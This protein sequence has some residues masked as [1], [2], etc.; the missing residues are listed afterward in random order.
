[1]STL[2]VND[3]VSL[4][5]ARAGDTYRMYDKPSQEVFYRLRRVAQIIELLTAEH[6]AQ[7]ALA[8][9]ED[10]VGDRCVGEILWKK[11]KPEIYA[12]LLGK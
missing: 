11:G 4:W 3:C 7:R 6:G 8:L 12:S 10:F 9:V 1:M 2:S 5:A